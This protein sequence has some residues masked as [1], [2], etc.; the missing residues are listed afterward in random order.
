MRCVEKWKRKRAKILRDSG[1]EYLGSKSIIKPAKSVKE[2]NHNCRYECKNISEE[3]RHAVFK[4]F[5]DLK[6]W[7]LQTSFINGC[8][9]TNTPKRS[10]N[11]AIKHKKVSICV[12]MCGKRVCKSFFI[13]TLDITVKR[14]DNVVKRRL[15]TNTGV[16]PKDQ[17][18][19]HTPSNKTDE[20]VLQKVIDHI[21]S[22]PKYSSHYSRAK[23]PSKKYLSSDLNVQQMYD[24]YAEKIK[25]EG[26]TPVK[27]TF[28]R[29]IFNTKFNLSF[30]KPLTDTCNKC[31]FFENK[32][33]HGENAKEVEES[34]IHKELH[35]RKADK[36]REAKTNAAKH[37][38]D[39][40]T[41]VKSICFDLQ[42][43]LP[44]PVLT[45]NRVYYAR[46]LWTYNLDIHDLG[47]NQGFMFM[48]HE[49]E[50]SRGSHEI[51]SCL[52]KYVEQ[53]PPSVKHLIAF[54]DNC[55]G[56]NKNQYISRFWM[57]I[58]QKTNI[59]T[60]DHKFLI[61]G[62]SYMEC[63]Q[64]FGMIEKSKKKH[65][66]VFVPDHWISAI[67]QANKKFQ[68]IRMSTKD[69]FSTE[70]MNEY[71]KGSIDGISQ[72]Q[73]LRFTKAE[74]LIVYYKTSLNEDLEFQK[75][76]MAKPKA[77]RRPTSFTLKPLHEQPVAITTAKYKDLQSLLPFL[78][79]IHH[80]FYKT[81]KHGK[82][83]KG[84]GSNLKHGNGKKNINQ[85]K[86][87]T[88]NGQQAASTSTSTEVTTCTLEEM[89]EAE[90]DLDRIYD[91]D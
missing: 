90:D 33:K 59:E 88:E 4:E 18:G 50:A 86:K 34:K 11:N 37:A 36:T 16:S 71:L 57:S 9:Q 45:C 64:D 31:D 39:N 70:S 46:Q 28:Y 2:Y 8:L 12:N 42:K 87:K 55:G 80:E 52:L 20:V 75:Y 85:K 38:K 58:V 7:D 29:H 22:F 1:K 91:S 65:Q 5:W 82:K 40:P 60:V 41:T 24:L 32:I 44:T 78:P 15:I 43:T 77:G 26:E 69:F 48:W 62:H 35:L 17:R 56:Q 47:E 84:Q 14:Y 27:V 10:R 79:P 83:E 68:V 67:A 3:E 89:A 23:N 54:S 76:D 25:K 73:W 74:P 81:L 72:F 49:A 13:K 63:D 61:P 30:K 6:S 19:K 51:G 66:Y 21:N 53:L